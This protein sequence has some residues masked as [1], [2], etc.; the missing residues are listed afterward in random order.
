MSER[1]CFIMYHDFSDQFELL[2]MSERGELI[3]AIFNY[4]KYGTIDKNISP[5]V[6]MAFSCM[7]NT[8]DR[9]DKKYAERCKKNSEN[10]KKGGRPK[11]DIFVSESECF[12]SKAKK[13]DRDRD[14]DRESDSDRDSDRD[15]DKDRDREREKEMERDKDRDKEKTEAELAPLDTPYGTLCGTTCGVPPQAP[16]EHEKEIKILVSK[17][18]DKAYIYER[19]ERAVEYA[20]RHGRALSDVLLEWWNGDRASGRHS[21]RTSRQLSEKEAKHR[22]CEEWFDARLSQLF[23]DCEA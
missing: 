2:D 19:L 11:K 14:K 5:V 4:A 20:E 12:F 6:K 3:T 8:L 21:T 9:D 1:N 13:A 16:L 22:E 17:G 18:V 7:K 23:G 10:G 15:R